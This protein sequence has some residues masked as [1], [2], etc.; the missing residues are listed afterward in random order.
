MKIVK[1]KEI[2]LNIEQE[3]DNYLNQNLI[4][5]YGEGE[6]FDP[7]DFTEEQARQF[8]TELSDEFIKQLRA[9]KRKAN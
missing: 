4:P 1:H 2:E 9:G 5:T 6:D 7:E 8:F 3:A